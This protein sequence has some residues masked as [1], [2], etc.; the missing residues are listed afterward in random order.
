M[1]TTAPTSFVP[2]A[3]RARRQRAFTLIELLVVIAIIAILASMLLPALSKAKAKAQGILCMNNTKQLGLAWIMYADDHDNK[4][5]HNRH[6]G[7]AQ[8]GANRNSWISGWLDWF[9]TPDNTNILF[10]ADENWAKLAPYSN[11]T[12]NLYKCPADKFL[13]NQQRSLRWAE[14]VRSIS[15]NSCMGDGNSK[16]WYG[17]A[18]TIYK[19]MSDMKALAPSHAWVFVDEHPDSINDGCAFVNVVEPQWVDLPASYHN[20]ACGFAFAD[21]HSE[22]KKWNETLTLRPV[23][24]VDFARTPTTATDRDLLWLRER[25]SE[26]QK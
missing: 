12:K 20:G 19:K 11:R 8:G 5:V 9:N 17:T 3:A 4:L 21:G 6:G 13:S 22:I 14:R 24:L 10:I 16:D 15:M 23:Q 26:P 18:H 7:D 2:S 25:T 1:T